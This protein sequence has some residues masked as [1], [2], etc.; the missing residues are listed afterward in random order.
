MEKEIDTHDKIIVDG[1]RR[2][3]EL[4]SRRRELLIEDMCHDW[5]LF[6]VSRELVLLCVSIRLHDAI[7]IVKDY[8]CFWAK[9][10]FFEWLM[11]LDPRCRRQIW[12]SHDRLRTKADR[13]NVVAVR[14]DFTKLKRSALHE[15]NTANS[16][17]VKWNRE[18]LVNDDFVSVDDSWAR[19]VTSPSL[20]IICRRLVMMKLSSEKAVRC[21]CKTPTGSREWGSW[22]MKTQTK[23]FCRLWLWPLSRF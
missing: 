5:L 19:P 4:S 14:L 23:T 6:C 3:I 7:S 10:F 12:S 16:T 18:S 15:A 17:T 8:Y 1:T 11:K 2:R 22:A 13:L 21:L 20:L 9:I